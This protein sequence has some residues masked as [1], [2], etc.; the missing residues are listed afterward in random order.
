MTTSLQDLSE[1]AGHSPRSAYLAETLLVLGIAVVTIY[2][3]YAFGLVGVDAQYFSNTKAIR[4][5]AETGSA[6]LAQLSTLESTRAWLEP[7]F[8]SGLALI[9]FGISISFAVSI[10]NMVKLR[11]RAATELLLAYRKR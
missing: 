6:V 4:D 3:V 11:A 10:L 9:L 5:A 8:F 1:K 2:A 7:V